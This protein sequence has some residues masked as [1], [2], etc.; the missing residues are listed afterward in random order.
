MTTE[1]TQ[2]T[3]TSPAAPLA[4]ADKPEPVSTP[5]PVTNKAKEKNP[6]GNKGVLV[7]LFLLILVLAAAVV[8]LGYLGWQWQQEQH[9]LQRQDE[10]QLSQQTI[11]WETMQQQ[12]DQ[13]QKRLQAPTDD[14]PNE[15][16][17]QL[18]SQLDQL[19]VRVN[20][21]SKRLQLL[22]TTSKNDWLLAEAEYLLRLANQR[23]LMERGGT[24][25]LALL[26]AADDI[27]LQLADMNLFPVREQLAR[28]IAALKLIPQVDRSGIYLTLSALAEQV[29]LL[30][31][32]PRAVDD[33]AEL[34]IAS[35]PNT[36]V[37]SYV[38]KN[39]WQKISDNFFA[40]MRKLGDQVRIRH[41]D[42]PLEVLLP[43][44]SE[45]YLRQ[46]IRF[47]LEQ[48][49]LALLREENAI[50]ANSLEQA[51]SLLEQYFPMQPQAQLIAAQ[52]GELAERNIRVELPDISS[53]LKQ[54][55][56]YTARLHKL[57]DSA[58]KSV[59]D[60]S[61]VSEAL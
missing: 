8:G 29:L 53:S 35:E 60:S 31:T 6:S 19:Q 59:T 54:L 23:L 58:A 42:Q 3:E 12:I 7:I 33:E 44:D 24:G 26:Q 39:L 15:L 2:N 9:G 41:H 4:K 18:Q 52:L 55:K 45:R 49:Q 22:S 30:P 38:T 37:V 47:N 1:E 25:P 48:A 46:N 20:G 32:V 36:D 11:R 50:Y 34:T 13:L 56:Q 28:D 61:Q 17:L 43:P 27:L 16:Q 40:A 5:P 51:K 21:Q 14:G 57:N 10:G